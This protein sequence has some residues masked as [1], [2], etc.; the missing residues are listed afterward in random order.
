MIISINMFGHLRSFK[1]CAQTI[2]KNIVQENPGCVFHLY[3]H[4]WSALNYDEKE[5]KASELHEDICK[6]Y[7]FLTIKSIKIEDQSTVTGM[8]ENDSF[9]GMRCMHYSL[10]ESVSNHLEQYDM[11]IFIRPDIYIIKK[12]KLNDLYNSLLKEADLYLSLYIH[13]HINTLDFLS[14]TGATDVFFIS[15][16]YFL[17]H[18]PS[19]KLNNEIYKPHSSGRM[20]EPHFFEFIENEGIKWKFM[21]MQ[22]NK[23]WIIYRKNV[24]F[25][26]RTKFYYIQLRRLFLESRRVLTSIIRGF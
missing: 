6:N 4:T 26:D 17:K 19:L 16:N 13:D 24:K 21:N 9:F 2:R 25:M 3:V 14:T 5:K 22:G 18:L 8:L 11:N 20:G 7:S 12:M 15:N 1:E 10:C 23:D